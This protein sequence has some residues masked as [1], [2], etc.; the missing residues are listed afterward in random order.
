M[1]VFALDVSDI[2]GELGDVGE[3]SLL[4]ARPRVR[5]FSHAESEGLVVRVS[6]ETP[7][8]QKVSEVSYPKIEREQFPVKCTVF[9]LRG[10]Q[11]FTEETQ[12]FPTATAGELPPLPGRKHQL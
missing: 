11:L 9:L 5:C 1:V 8:L 6:N 2:R 7:A 3:V 12:G 10:L 4:S